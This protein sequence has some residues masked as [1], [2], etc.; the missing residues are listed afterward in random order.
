MNAQQYIANVP[1]EA[2][3]LYVRMRGRCRGPFNWQQLCTMVANGELSRLHELSIDN[4]QWESAEGYSLLFDYNESSK[5][6]DAVT[7][8]TSRHLPVGQWFYEMD[9]QARGPVA[10]QVLRNWILHCWLDLP[11]RVWSV[12]MNDWTEVES[13][14]SFVQPSEP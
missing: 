6:P 2:L 14:P 12:G 3:Y 8:N 11:A 5:S 4:Q 1:L 10:F 7:F 13:I 9:D